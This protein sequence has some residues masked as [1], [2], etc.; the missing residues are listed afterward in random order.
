MK[1]YITREDALR[2]ARKAW[3]EHLPVEKCIEAV[4]AAS[5]F[6][7]NPV[8][9]PFDT[10]CRQ[11]RHCEVS[12]DGKNEPVAYECI[13]GSDHFGLPEGCLH[14]EEWEDPDD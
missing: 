14:Y 13:E 5:V 11:C 3:K 10:V 2:A 7:I 6:E 1:E 12:G 4:P 8:V 9:M